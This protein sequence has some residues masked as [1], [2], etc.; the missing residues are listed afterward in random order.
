MGAHH[1]IRLGGTR[2]GD[3]TGTAGATLCRSADGG[4]RAIAAKGDGENRRKAASGD[5]GQKKR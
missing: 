5:E 2:I 3:H 1:G 4:S